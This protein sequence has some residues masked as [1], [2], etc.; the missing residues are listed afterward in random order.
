VTPSAAGDG[1][2][3]TV[4]YPVKR[5]RWRIEAACDPCCS[6]KSVRTSCSGKSVRTKLMDAAARVEGRREGAVG[7]S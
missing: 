7:V 4:M 3:R 5:R 1:G 2:L 6:G